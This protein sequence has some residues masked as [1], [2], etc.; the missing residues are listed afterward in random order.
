[1]SASQRY[2]AHKHDHYL[3]GSYAAA[4]HS[5]SGYESDESVDDFRRN[6]SEQISSLRSSRT[7]SRASSSR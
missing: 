7:H 4:L 2:H 5:P 1:M 6:L 3:S